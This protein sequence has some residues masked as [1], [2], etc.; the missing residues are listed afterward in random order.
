M[1]MADY[2]TTDG[3]RIGV[4]MGSASDWPTMKRRVKPFISSESR[5]N[6]MQSQRTE[7][8]NGFK[9]T[10]QMLKI[11]V[12]NYL[13]VQLAAPRISLAL[14]QPTQKNPYWAAQCRHGRSMAS[15]PSSQQCKCQK[16]CQLQPLQLAPL[17]RSTLQLLLLKCSRWAILM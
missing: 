17:V 14:L 15:I 10:S 12:S 6:A 8:Q 5:M 9:S 11:A 16:G 13:S 1:G 2:T 7:T 4:L 3:A